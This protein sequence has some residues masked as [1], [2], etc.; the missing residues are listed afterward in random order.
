MRPH[1]GRRRAGCSAPEPPQPAD[2]GARPHRTDVQRRVRTPGGAQRVADRARA[3]APAPPGSTSPSRRSRWRHRSRSARGRRRAPGAQQRQL[4]GAG[5]PDDAA[6]DDDGGVLSHGR[7]SAARVASRNALVRSCWGLSITCSGGPSSTIRPAST[8]E[9]RSETRRANGTSCVTMTIVMPPSASSRITVSTSRVDSGSSADVGSSN[10]SAVGLRAS[11]LAMATRCCSPPDICSGNASARCA[12]P[13][14]RISRT[15]VS[16]AW[17]SEIPA[18]LVCARITFSIAVR[19]GNR[20]NRWKTMPTFWRS[21]ARSRA[22]TRVPENTVS[23]PTCTSPESGT[24][25]RLMQRSSVLLPPPLWPRI[26][27]ISP[28]ATLRSTSV[29]HDVGAEGLAQVLHR[30]RRAHAAPPGASSS[31]FARASRRRRP[32]V[33]GDT[34]RHLPLEEQQELRQRVADDEVDAPR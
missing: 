27:T 6:A 9:T 22:A 31:T 7:S 12:S 17:S 33:S 10:S 4:V 34:R 32:G 28:A 1:R 20:L 15:A 23:S 29:E 5:E 18:A 11:A 2:Q 26:V 16:T 14:R 13:T 19:C 30:D 24:S 3:R 25:S 21:R 8:N